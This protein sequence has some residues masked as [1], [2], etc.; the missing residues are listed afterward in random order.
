M[1]YLCEYEDADLTE[2]LSAIASIIRSHKDP[3]VASAAIQAWIATMSLLPSR[4]V[5][6]SI[7]S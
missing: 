6:S 7:Q 2:F 4:T 5:L 1:F 3:A